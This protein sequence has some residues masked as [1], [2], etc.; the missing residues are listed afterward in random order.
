MQWNYLK[1]YE[2]FSHQLHMLCQLMSG[3]MN[4]HLLSLSQMLSRRG[5]GTQEGG[6]LPEN[7]DRVVWC[8]SSNRYPIS[9]QT[10]QFFLSYFKT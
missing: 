1:E 4:E 8:V 9:D 2:T 10:M 7:L 3:Y 6:V 5:A